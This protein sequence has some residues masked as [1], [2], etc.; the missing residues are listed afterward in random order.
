[1]RDD[2]RGPKDTLSLGEALQ[3]D[4]DDPVIGP[5]LEFRVVGSV[6]SVDIAGVHPLLDHAGQQ[7]GSRTR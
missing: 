2:G 5:M 7:P 6:P 4:D 3:G 1:M